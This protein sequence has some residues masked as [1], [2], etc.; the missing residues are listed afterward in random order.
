MY[1]LELTEGELSDV[2]SVTADML[3]AAGCDLP[4]PSS[5]QRAR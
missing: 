1:K 3:I 2:A 4:H 5:L